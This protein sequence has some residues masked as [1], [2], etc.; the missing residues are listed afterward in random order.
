MACAWLLL[1]DPPPVA[2]S[3]SAV[4]A[5]SASAAAG[6]PFEG[7]GASGA[8]W[9]RDTGRLPAATRDRIADLLFS[10]SGLRLSMYRYNIGGGGWIS[11]RAR[12]APGYLRSD[13]TYDWSADPAGRD[14]LSRAASMGVPRLVAF[15]NAAPPA[16][17]TNGQGCA[18]SLR[19][20]RVSQYASYLAH[21]VTHLSS[22]GTRIDLVSPMNEPDS[23]FSTC[24]QEGMAVPVALRAPLVN[25]VQAALARRGS[26]AG[27]LADE[28]GTAGRLVSESPGWLADA[29]PQVL[30]YHAYDNPD[31]QRLQGV[32]TV[33]AQAGR[34]AYMS[35]VCCL[36]DGHFRQ[37]FHPR[38][39]GAL[40][41]AHAIWRNLALGGASSFSWWVA[42]SPEL[43]CDAR[44]RSCGRT[45]N[46][47]G[48]DDGLVYYDRDYRADGNTRLVLTKRYWAYAQF[49]RWIRPG[50]T[51]HAVTGDTGG[52]RVLAYTGHAH[53]VV[54]AV[55][56]RGRVSPLS[57]GL[58]WLGS[59]TASVTQT[60]GRLSDASLPPV[61]VTGGTLEAQL[62]GGSVS[63]FVI[64]G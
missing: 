37:G 32:A 45:A 64:P 49:T 24:T 11:R 57:L 40:W 26:S 59:A 43:G 54:V 42:L 58:P 22:E 53:T 16:F 39:R 27:V 19:A 2:D 61:P 56:P 8:W 62:P 9:A 30:A 20:D 33:A 14:M 35:E 55:A 36:V 51:P 31:M 41:M 5:A 52:A 10:R 38:M 13:G 21:V 6:A 12:F 18:G 63:T 47:S 3:A 4:P 28:S 23:A 25:A 44:D 15:A 7:F 60:S 34:P 17:T 1:V 48:W 29:T 50:M 46:G